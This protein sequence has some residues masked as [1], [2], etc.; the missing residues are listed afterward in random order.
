MAVLLSQLIEG[1]PSARVIHSARTE[2][3]GL[4]YDSRAVRPGDL[5]ICI[6]GFVYDG[7]DFAGQA[8]EKGAVALLVE[9]PLPL[10]V[11]QIVVDDSRRAMGPLAAAFYGYPSSQLRV[12]GVT[13]TNGKT[14]TTYF[15]RSLLAHAGRRCGLIG[16]VVQSAGQGDAPATRTTPEAVDIQRLL[17][18]MVDNGCKAAVMEVSSHG[19]VLQRTAGVEFDIA[20]FTNLTQD[21]F[22]FHRT[23]DDYLEA[24]LK[25]FRGLAPGKTSLKR[26]K[27]AVV[28]GDDPHAESFIKASQVPV[29]TYGFSPERDLWAS[30]VEVTPGGVR[31]LARSRRQTVEVRLRL[32]GRFNV[33]NSLAALGVALGEGIDLE[34]AVLGIRETVVP[35]RF[36]PV[37]LGQEFAVIVDYAHTPDSLE[38]VL[39]TARSLAKE[40]VICVFGAGG[41]RDPTKRPD[42]GRDRR[43][44]GRLRR[45]HLRQP[46]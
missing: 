8:V 16:T 40:R 33:Y 17:R 31:Y 6:R 41:D 13:G 46:T 11:P 27:C 28:N 43:G 3:S 45:H 18:Q 1:L 23:F 2:V 39:K 35:G 20:V 42:H 22:D 5:F 37:D 25:L 10:A 30:D 44:A 34:E 36:E 9:R 12:V 14:T 29:I 38:N 26:Q 32:T 24:K 7:H 4:A 21:H 15:V 19:L